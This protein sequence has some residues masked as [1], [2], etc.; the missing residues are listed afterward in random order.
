MRAVGARVLLQASAVGIY[1][2]CGDD[3][4]DEGSG[5]GAG[6]LAELT[7]G[8]RPLWPV[9]KRGFARSCCGPETS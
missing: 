3:S 2:D 8:G 6:F 4:V 1:G 7:Q 9:L 5:A